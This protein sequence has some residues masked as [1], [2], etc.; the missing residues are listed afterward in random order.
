MSRFL[1]VFL[2]TLMA[3]LLVAGQTSVEAAKI[4]FV[5][6]NGTRHENDPFDKFLYD[7][8]ESQGHT[9][10]RGANATH[11]DDPSYDGVCMFIISDDGSSGSIGDTIDA[12]GL[13]DPRPVIMYEAGAHDNFKIGA[14]KAYRNDVANGQVDVDIRNIVIVDPL[15]PAAGGLSGTVNL[16]DVAPQTFGTPTRLHGVGEDL[17]NG[18]A[19][20]PG[21]VSV[22]TSVAS[23]FDDPFFEPVDPLNNNEPLGPSD[24]ITTI[25]YVPPG[26]ELNDGTFAAG[27]RMAVFFNDSE[28]DGSGGILT[29][30]AVTL[31]DAITGFALNYAVC[32]PEPS[33]LALSLLGLVSIGLRRRR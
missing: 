23:S 30:D 17:D 32:V 8:L 14:G 28:D 2:A 11:F 15:E 5:N 24:T 6:G 29:A 21:L 7:R 22:A 16:Y 3:L 10:V 20:A 26:G 4:A 9:M 33:T 19:L 31:V 27:L 13:N 25:G 1:S 12:G 18:I